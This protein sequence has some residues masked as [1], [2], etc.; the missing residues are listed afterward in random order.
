MKD[1]QQKTEGLIFIN[2]NHELDRSMHFLKV[3]Q[4]ILWAIEE[5]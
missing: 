1:R 3:I 5:I 4:D 2:G